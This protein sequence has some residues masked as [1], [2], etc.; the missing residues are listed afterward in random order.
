[1]NISGC[2]PRVAVLLAAYNGMNY[3][4]EQVETILA[5]KDVDL[6]VFFS[7]DPSS[8]GTE[9]W[10]LE[11]AKNNPKV[12]ILPGGQRFGGAARNFFYLVRE[13]DFSG[14]DY[15]SFADQDDIWLED[16]LIRAHRQLQIR[17]CDAYSSNVL[18]FWPDGRESII[19]KAQPQVSH[20][21]L[22]EAAGPGCTYVLTVQSALSMKSFML[23][24]WDEVN[25]V[26][27]H[28]WFFYA[29][30]RANGLCWF[31][32]SEWRM[33]Y[34][35]HGGNQVGA[36]KGLAAVLHRISLLRSGWYRSEVIRIAGL[37]SPSSDRLAHILCAKGRMGL[38]ELIP[39]VGQ[40]R[41]RMSDRLFLCA[42]ILLGLF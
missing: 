19:N 13:V 34:R 39:H 12:I 2:L 1:M 11:L 4:A 5:Q 35:Q 14:F 42:V 28:D 41:R 7:V 32:D 40:L 20:D 24:H 30:Y 31:I 27:L 10:V 6:T 36:N 16:K 22:F 21:Y 37:I 17:A 26:G 29:W 3:I 15:I 23:K 25:Q 33:R 9:D 18:A 38:L 8:D